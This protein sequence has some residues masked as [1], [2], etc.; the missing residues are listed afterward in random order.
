MSVGV[1][2]LT[3]LLQSS[4]DPKTIIETSIFPQYLTLAELEAHQL[5]ATT[6]RLFTKLHTRFR[7]LP[8]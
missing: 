2:R 7:H 5:L 8:S 4:I 6:C 3:V 1:V